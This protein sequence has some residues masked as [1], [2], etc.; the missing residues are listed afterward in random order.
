[1]NGHRTYNA[2]IEEI[3]AVLE[4]DQTL[5][6]L[7]SIDMEGDVK[8]LDEG[9]WISTNSGNKIRIDHPTHGVGKTH[10][11]LYG[12]KGDILGVVN[13]DGTPSHGTE[14]KINKKDAE[15]LRSYGF[16]IPKDRLVEWI[17]TDRQE[18]QIL[19]G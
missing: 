18:L 3:T 13:L 2:I 7:F 9:K 10:A 16:N 12:R 4:K 6:E 17:Q 5:D 8:R 14:M 15:T 19:L 11:H 1:M